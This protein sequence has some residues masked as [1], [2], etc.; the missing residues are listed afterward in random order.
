[1]SGKDEEPDG[2]EE[3]PA[4]APSVP[5]DPE[6]VFDNSMDEVELPARMTDKAIDDETAEEI[7][8]RDQA[9]VRE[10]AGAE[11][12]AHLRQMRQDAETVC[13]TGLRPAR[14]AVQAEGAGGEDELS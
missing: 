14:L 7:Q 9:P 1:M 4:E 3:E 8:T 12:Q 10:Q 13:E 2:E 11:R 5:D 6:A